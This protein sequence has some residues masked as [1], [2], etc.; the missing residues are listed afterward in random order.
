VALDFFDLKSMI[1]QIEITW[2][3]AR[4]LRYLRSE[5]IGIADT[6]NGRLGL[7]IEER[8]LMQGHA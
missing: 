1:Y 6:E 5:E 2:Q 7:L 8:D 3:M 4:G